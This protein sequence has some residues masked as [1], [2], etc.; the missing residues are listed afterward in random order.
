MK[1]KKL[2]PRLHVPDY[3]EVETVKDEG[4]KTIW[5]APADAMERARAFIR[6]C[7]QSGKPTLLVPDKD[8]DGLSSGVILHRT[9]TALG[10]P[11][12]LISTHIVTKGS[13]I[14]DSTERDLMSTTYNPSYI[15]V[16]DQ[17]SRAAP[18]VIDNSSTKSLILDH[19]LSDS[20][21]EDALVVS[22]CHYP[23]VATTSLLTYLTCLPL[24]PSPTTF[25]ESCA[26]LACIGTHGDLGNTLK[27]L[28]PFPDLTPTLKQHTKKAINEARLDRAP[29]LHLPERPS[30]PPS[31]SYQREPK[32]T[33]KSNATRTAPRN[34]PPTAASPCCAS[35]PPPKFTP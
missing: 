30:H 16:L 32:S 20:F 33:P 23:P 4:G 7:A 19:H 17:G 6:A 10:L 27:W 8:A 28:P 13:S 18:R 24:H 9:L 35:T 15:I 22:A 26:Y 5:P 11:T 25:T 1:E 21:P 12:D 34:S 3:C 2:K 29:S 14:H 31:P